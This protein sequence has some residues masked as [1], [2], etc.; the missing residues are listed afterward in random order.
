M[1]S[2]NTVIQTFP[3]QQT[4]PYQNP[5]VKNIAT[6]TGVVPQNVVNPNGVVTC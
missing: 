3:Q 5:L 6:I 2:N 1:R 4:T